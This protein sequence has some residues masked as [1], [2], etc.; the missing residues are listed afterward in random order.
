MTQP[1]NHR[2]FA[3]RRPVSLRRSTIA[4]LDIGTNKIACM[5][6]ESSD[7]A[8]TGEK[9]VSPGRIIGFGQHVSD[10]INAGQVTHMH[11]AEDSIRA[12][13]E[14]AE[15]MAGVE[16][17]NVI[18]GLS[19]PQI[20]SHSFETSVALHGEPVSE[21]H[22]EHAM[23]SV[24]DR[25]RSDDSEIL[26]AIPVTYAIDQSVGISDPRGM[27]GHG[28]YVN[29]HMMRVPA[30][31]VRNLLAC[32]EQ[33]HL[34][35]DKL[36]A[37][38]YAGALAVLMRDEIDLG[39]WHIDL[40]GGT[41][42]IGVYH[43]GVPVF[44]AGIPVGGEHITRD[45]ARGLNVSMVVAE[46]LKTLYGSALA[47]P[48]GERD[49]FELPVLGGDHQT[50][51]RSELTKIIRPRLEE[52]YELL[53]S[54]VDASSA[55]QVTGGRIVLSGGGAQLSGAPELAQT[56]FE[57]QVR[58]GQPIRL[59]G[60]PESAGGPAFAACA[61]LLTYAAR[62]QHDIISGDDADGGALNRL[63]NWLRRNF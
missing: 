15:R 8:V 61:G 6:A 63:R 12:A 41:S 7:E 9:E 32:V 54:R 24:F 38:P 18:I 47:S 51:P 35:C 62:S 4:A 20:E 53:L 23:R 26:H 49:Q 42:S 14:A 22:M 1:V 2:Q 46:R 19:M 37:T 44:I 27:Y 31:P 16:V 30:G 28:L 40:G 45:I 48:K 57:K 10:G 50:L 58:V 5:I 13:V 3:R 17:R 34:E 11:A 43:Q 56:I 55:G 39:A 59:S 29:Q 25:F 60:L 36:V 21:E 33:C 52:I